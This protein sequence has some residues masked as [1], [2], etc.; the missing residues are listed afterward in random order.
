MQK[1]VI[2]SQN[3]V[4]INSTRIGFKK[5]FPRRKFEFI[6]VSA[7]SGVSDQP[8]NKEI[9]RGALNRAKNVSKLVPNADFWVG[10]EG[11]VEESDKQM[12]SFTWIV[13]KGK[14]NVV[15]K[16]ATGSFFLPERVAKLIRQGKELGEA[17][18]EVFKK[19]N[20]KQLNGAVGILTGDIIT[21][22]TFYEMAVILALIPFKNSDLY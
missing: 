4:K 13:I 15:G 7:P 11:G 22:T 18:D 6:G 10:I 21:R 17:I 5:M 12:K 8:R 3:P 1:V 20:S 14:N 16:G 9:L 2:A 19:N